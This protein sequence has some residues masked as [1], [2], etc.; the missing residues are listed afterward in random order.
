[1]KS[2]DQRKLLRDI[3]RLVYLSKRERYRSA[4]K[5]HM[6]KLRRMERQAASDAKMPS[7]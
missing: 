6:R 2:G 7:P 5:R 4:L 3:L 1:M